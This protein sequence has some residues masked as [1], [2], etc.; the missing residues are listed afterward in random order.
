MTQRLPKMQKIGAGKIRYGGFVLEYLRT[1]TDATEAN[2]AVDMI[3]GR[4]LE[5]I[6][7]KE[8]SRLHL[9]AQRRGH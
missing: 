7:I 1:E 6:L 3:R 9:Y 5:A 2:K 8:D 4:G